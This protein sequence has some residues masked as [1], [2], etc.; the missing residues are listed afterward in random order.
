MLVFLK[1]PLWIGF[2]AGGLEICRLKVEEMLSFEQ[3]LS[4]EIQLNGEKNDLKIK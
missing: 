4:L 3:S 2:N 1:S